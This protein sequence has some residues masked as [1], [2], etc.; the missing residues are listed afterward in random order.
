MDDYSNTIVFTDWYQVVIN[1]DK[2]YEMPVPKF[3]KALEKELIS[4]DYNVFFN[5]EKKKFIISFKGNDYDV[6][7]NKDEEE[8]LLSGQYS[9]LIL[10]LLWLSKLEKKYNDE[11]AI[12]EVRRAKIEAF[13]KSNYEYMETVEDYELYLEFLKD[14]LTKAEKQEEKNAINTKIANIIPIISKMKKEEVR[15]VENPLD[16]QLHINRFIHNDLKQIE[17]L[18]DEN[19]K[20]LANEI[21]GIILDYRS[22]VELY[23]QKKKD[24]L[25]LG[26]PLLPMDILG[27]IIDVEFKIKKAMKSGKLSSYVKD[28]LSSLE[29]KL[30]A[31][32]NEEPQKS[33]R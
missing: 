18:D 32:I 20:A 9:P 21:K 4:T 27:R 14:Q 10:K 11:R 2:S 24:G 5:E 28:S 1:K 31:I 6:I 7:F 26:N 29:E 23:N 3:L 17:E 19:R 16:L 8:S 25:F 15:R 33:K 12:Q 13:I 22:R 30:N